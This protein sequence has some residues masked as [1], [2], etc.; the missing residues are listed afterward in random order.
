MN[1]PRYPIGRFS[2]P[3]GEITPQDLQAA[4]DAI[5]ALPSE[6]R[7]ETSGLTEEQLES[8]YREG[9]WTVRQ[10]VHHVADSH[11]NS[12]ARFRKALTE[13]EPL[14]FAYDEKA[15]AELPDARHESIGIS[16][17]MLDAIHRRWTI[18]LRSLTP[19]QWKRTFRHPEKGLMRLDATALLYAWHGHHHLAHVTNLRQRGNW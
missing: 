18:L 5:A 10:L 11:L 13:V 17:E 6:L 15:W 12:Y 9:G 8:P 1:D 2:P 3:A 4:I 16:L 7:A 14:I 19:E